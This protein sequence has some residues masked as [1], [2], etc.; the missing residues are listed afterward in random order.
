MKEFLMRN[1]VKNL[2]TARFA[3]AAFVFLLSVFSVCAVARGEASQQ[4]DPPQWILD[5]EGISRDDFMTGREAQHHDK[6]LTE[7]EIA[8]K[9]KKLTDQYIS[10]GTEPLIAQD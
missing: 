10:E 5:K 2:R 4:G 8:D 1:I 7:S 3:V 6:P 9:I